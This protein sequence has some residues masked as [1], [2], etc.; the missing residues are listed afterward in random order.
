MVSTVS[1]YQW[2]HEQENPLS[3][4]ILLLPGRS[5]LSDHDVL[6]LTV[7]LVYPSAHVPSSLFED[8]MSTF[9]GHLSLSRRRDKLRLSLA[10]SLADSRV[11]FLPSSS[12]HLLSSH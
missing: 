12:D 8:T 10:H 4:V 6:P 1:A 9:E 7:Q 3:F 5:V 2:Q 11:S